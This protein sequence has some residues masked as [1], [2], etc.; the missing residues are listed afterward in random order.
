M[1]RERSVGHTGARRGQ[2]LAE[3]ALLLPILLV[4]AVGS[5]D[6]GRAYFASVALEHA[7]MEGAV[8]GA[9]DPR[10]ATDTGG[11]CSDPDNVRAHVEVELN[12]TTLSAFEAKC[13]ASGT[14]VYSGPGKP[15]ADCE[16]GDVYWVHAETPFRLVTPLVEEIVGAAGLH[17]D[18]TA[19]SVVRTSAGTE[20]SSR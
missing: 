17:I 16:E 20:A 18:S 13:F 14:T 1:S 7:V 9:H 3:L 19:T 5:I 8:Y 4:I 11:H 10:C 15:L 2:S 12:G 6:L